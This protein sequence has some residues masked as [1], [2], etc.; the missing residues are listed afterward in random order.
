MGFYDS[1]FDELEKIGGLWEMG[2]T[3]YKLNPLN[4]PSILAGK[5]ARKVL[6]MGAKASSSALKTTGKVLGGPFKPVSKV[7]SKP[8]EWISK[9]PDWII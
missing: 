6:G 5:A 2:K 3:L 8:S 7:V 1:F 9:H 4:W